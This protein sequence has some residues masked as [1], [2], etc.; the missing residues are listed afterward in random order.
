MATYGQWARARRTSRVAW[1]CGD[2]PAL[3]RDVLA[4]WRALA[5]GQSA[6]LFA[7][8]A[9]ERDIWDQVLADPSPGGR[10]VIVHGAERLRAPGHVAVLAGPDAADTAYTVFVSAE[11]DFAREVRDGKPALAPHLAALQASKAGQLIRCCRPAKDEDVIRLVAGWW[12]GAGA[13]LAAEVLELCGGSLT[14]AWQAC[15]TAVRAG[16]EPTSAMAALACP[17]GR[18]PGLADRLIAGDRRGALAEAGRLGHGETGAVLGLLAARLAALAEI[19][20]LRARE[21]P[22]YRLDRYLVHLLGPHA[23]DYGP[24]RI[25]RCREVLAMLESHWRSGADEG[26]AEALCALW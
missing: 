22:L 16:L 8:D 14:A 13:V 23:R 3:V 24:D 4:A 20:E 1:V 15:D 10:C 19:S 26:V 18:G 12:P 17:P 21:Q 11:P 2:E 25:S 9:P 6:V 5:P 7:G